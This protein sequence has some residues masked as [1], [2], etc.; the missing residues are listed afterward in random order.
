MARRASVSDSS[1]AK[2]PHPAHN[3]LPSNFRS[4]VSTRAQLSGEAGSTIM[5]A[6]LPAGERCLVVDLRP[7]RAR[8]QTERGYHPVWLRQTEAELEKRG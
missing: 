5:T 2:A 3:A 6:T 4:A 7:L 8:M 1:P